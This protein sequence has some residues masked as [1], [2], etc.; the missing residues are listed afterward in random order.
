[1][2]VVLIFVVGWV[3]GDMPRNSKELAKDYEEY[4]ARNI[5]EIEDRLDKGYRV[6][7]QNYRYGKW[8]ENFNVSSSF[9]A[10]V[11]KYDEDWL[12]I[13]DTY[14]DR[15]AENNAFYDRAD[16]KFEEDYPKLIS[17]GSKYYPNGFSDLSPEG[18]QAQLDHITGGKRL[19][20]QEWDNLVTQGYVQ[21]RRAMFTLSQDLSD[22][23]IRDALNW[24][25]FR[26]SVFYLGYIN[27]VMSEM[28]YFLNMD[29]L[30][31]DRYRVIRS[32][33]RERWNR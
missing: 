4:K 31:R 22:Q 28:E 10:K 5:K 17:K 2:V 16:Q 13:L 29:Q 20:K 18:Q 12:K 6:H 33:E 21:F 15:V 19:F 32:A 8:V 7:L 27:R 9:K 26:E 3:Y 11:A 1:M 30:E 14:K 25:I 24:V 23:N